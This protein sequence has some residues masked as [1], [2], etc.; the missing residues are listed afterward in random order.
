LVYTG[1]ELKS[2]GRC[3]DLRCCTGCSLLLTA[4]G[5]ANTA[6]FKKGEN[7]GKKKKRRQLNKKKIKMTYSLLGITI[8]IWVPYQVAYQVFLYILCHSRTSMT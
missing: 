1:F 6:F 5:G 4:K 2:S 8:E 7:D 3:G